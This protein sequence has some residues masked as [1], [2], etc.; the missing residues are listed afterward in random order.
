VEVAHEVLKKRPD[1]HFLFVG[2]GPLRVEIQERARELG[3]LDKIHFPGIRT[4]VPR[5]MRA[6]MNVFVFPSLWEGLP[7]VIIEAQAAGLRCIV[8]DAVTNEVS[9]LPEQLQWLPLSAGAETWAAATVHA[10]ERER[11]VRDAALQ[12]IAQTDFCTQKSALSELYL[13]AME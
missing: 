13:T 12:A 11:I 8:S 3:L 6:A 2:D 9:I 10:L 4:D 5:L 7:L 1:V